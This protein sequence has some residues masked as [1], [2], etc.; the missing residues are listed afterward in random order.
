MAFDF[1][2]AVESDFENYMLVDLG[3]TV[4]YYSRD[5]IVTYE[6]TYGYLTGHTLPGGTSMSIIIA[7]FT[8]RDKEEFDLGNLLVDDHKAYIPNSVTPE[9][10]DYIDRDSDSERYEIVNVLHEHAVAGTKTYYT[11]HIRRRSQ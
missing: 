9:C 4:T 3:E 6:A 11:V 10:G 5:D 8:Q 1:A 2:G 7:T